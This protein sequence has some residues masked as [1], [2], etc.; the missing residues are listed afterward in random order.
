MALRAKTRRNLSATTPIPINTSISNV[1]ATSIAASIVLGAGRARS[2]IAGVS[3]CDRVGDP[4]PGCAENLAML[5]VAP[6]SVNAT[7]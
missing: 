5:T 3:K 1:L 7:A 2:R 6:Q 4:S